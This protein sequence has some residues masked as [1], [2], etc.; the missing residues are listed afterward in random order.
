[1]SKGMS[2]EDFK[3]QLN[4]DAQARCIE[5]EKTIHKLIE[6]LKEKDHLIESLEKKCFV[7]TYG[8]CCSHCLHNISCK[9]YK[10]HANLPVK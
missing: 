6:E 5:Q 8:S 3:T 7:G 10:R 9:V 1:M 2:F 4:T